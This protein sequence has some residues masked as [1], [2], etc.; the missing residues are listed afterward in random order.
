MSYVLRWYQE[1]AVNAIYNYF[2]QGGRGNPVVAMPTGS[3][4]SLVIAEFIKRT[5]MTWSNQRCLMLTH[6]KELIK[7]DYD[8]LIEAWPFAPAGIFSAGLKQKNASAPI[9]FGGIASVVN[10]LAEFNWFDLVFVDEAHLISD[11]ESSM[12][13]QVITHLRKINPNLKVIAFSATIFRLGMGM[14]TEGKLFTDVCYDITGV[15]PINRLIF[16]GYLSALIPRPT[17][18]KL[19]VTNVGVVR[20]EYKQG[21]VAK[22]VDKET[23]TYAACQEAIFHGHDRRVWLAFSSGIEHAEHISSMLNGLGISATFVHSKISAEERDNRI[24]AFKRGRFRAM[25][26]ANILTTGFD[27]PPIDMILMLRPTMSAGLWVQM[28]G[29]GMRPYVSLSWTKHNCLVLDY[30]G[31]T[32]RLGPINDPV[33]PNPK[34]KTPG[35]APV[36][37]C[38]RCGDLNHISVRFCISCGFEF[39]FAVKIEEKASGDALLKGDL[40]QVETY[41]VRTVVI[42]PHIKKVNGVEAGFPT[43]QIDYY[44]EGRKKPIKEFVSFD[45]RHKQFFLKISRDWWKKRHW[46]RPPSNNDEALRYISELRNPRQI[47]VHVNRDYPEII[48]YE[49]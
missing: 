28:L 12:Y 4:K 36:K 48:G 38:E 14:L 35:I 45:E 44:V 41:N 23:I 49:W 1:D 9:T 29:R 3:G 7:Q 31:N 16:E 8:K 13:W 19:D 6:R 27:H 2:V 34:S 10:A 47:R 24:A 17:K 32:R 18:T 20:G 46:T 33:I 22:A 39:G 40:P 21:E 43:L 11:S 30:A 42:N 26:N 37:T 25:V 15:E 5:L